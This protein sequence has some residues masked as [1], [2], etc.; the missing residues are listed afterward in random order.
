MG[1]THYLYRKPELRTSDFTAF[2]A[3]ART[4]L[5]SLELILQRDHQAGLAGPHGSNVPIVTDELV[6]FNGAV[7]GEY[8][9]CHIPRKLDR[10]DYSS[11]DDAGRAF[12]FCK[13]AEKP[14]DV[15]VTAIYALTVD[16]FGDDVAVD[17]DG[18][19]EAIEAGRLLA[20][21]LLGRTLRGATHP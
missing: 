4:L 21:K 9:T 14:Y 17:S 7:P 6:S 18:G 10:D 2:A 20:S 5:A 11:A 8:E 19:A 13:T 16:H 3:E 15:A 1:Y 12:S